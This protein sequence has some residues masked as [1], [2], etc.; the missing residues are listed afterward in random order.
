[1]YEYHELAEIYGV[2]A[3]TIRNWVRWGKL[4]SVCIKKHKYIS[5][6][7]LVEYMR[8]TKKMEGAL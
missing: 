7:A 2:T 4:N 3:T 5:K 6:D 8:G 1:M